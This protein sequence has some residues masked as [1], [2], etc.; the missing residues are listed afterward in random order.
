[1]PYAEQRNVVKPIYENLTPEETADKISALLTPK[2]MQA[3]V[4]I[5]YQG[6]QGLHA[7]IPEHKGDWYFTGNFPTPGGNRVV[8]RAF[9]FWKEGR[10]D[11]AY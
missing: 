4:R 3:E 2:G 1:K 5:I 8:N 9:V 6:I 10:A 11:R 7:A